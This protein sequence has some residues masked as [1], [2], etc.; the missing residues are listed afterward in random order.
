MSD[1]TIFLVNNR[2]R[3]M[4]DQLTTEIIRKSIHMLIALVPLLAAWNYG[5]T[6]TLMLMGIVVYT[7]SEFLR[8][9]G[10]E[11]AIISKLTSA[12]ARK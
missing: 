6:V 4:I 8:Q 5:L 10:Y 7:Y 1:L 9:Q 3:P 2:Q 11:V 12:A